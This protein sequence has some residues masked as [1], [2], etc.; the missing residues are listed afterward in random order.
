MNGL[1]LR[2]AAAVWVLLLAGALAAS[3]LRVS[4][5]A[6]I[7]L[8]SMDTL[9]PAFS[10]DGEVLAYFL[11]GGK[12]AWVWNAETGAARSA[13]ETGETL[14]RIALNPDG[15]LL[16]T[17]S[18]SG[19]AQVWDT[20]SGTR[21]FDVATRALPTWQV[22]FFDA[23]TLA[24]ASGSF[25]TVAAWDVRSGAHH[26][27]LD[28][29]AI[30]ITDLIFQPG[31][32][33]TKIQESRLRVWPLDGGTARAFETGEPLGEL[34]LLTPDG[35]DLLTYNRRAF[36]RV[37]DVERGRLA[38][39]LDNFALADAA[40]AGGRILVAGWGS[41]AP[42]WGLGVY[43][44]R[45]GKLL[46][47][48]LG[49]WAA[50]SDDGGQLAGVVYTRAHPEVWLWETETWTGRRL[51]RGS[52]SALWFSPDGRRLAL[53]DTARVLHVLTIKG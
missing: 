39:R 36:A 49:G 53:L 12:R 6:R 23:H 27:M 14:Y 47:S 52:V 26:S 1:L 20:M 16:A 19:L 13:I 37:W 24:L 50:F 40:V 34:V 38:S 4:E 30:E 29:P 3:G 31:W 33:V 51:W 35:R 8:A 43:D 22:G 42:E 10:A 18:P 48:F 21:V 7:P 17:V 5:T 45:E 9:V 44:A 28:H 11:D 25:P 15:S 46:H 32:A 41:S 2:G